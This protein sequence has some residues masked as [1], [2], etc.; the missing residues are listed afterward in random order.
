MD[1]RRV[2]EQP[3]LDRV[4]QQLADRARVDLGKLE[5]REQHAAG[6]QHRLDLVGA[7]HVGERGR[8]LAQRGTARVEQAPPEARGGVGAVGVGKEDAELQVSNAGGARL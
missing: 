3:I 1:V 5:P 6:R 4:R 2:G 7:R 8:V